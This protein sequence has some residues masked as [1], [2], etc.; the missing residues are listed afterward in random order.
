VIMVSL[1][2]LTLSQS[3]DVSF[4]IGPGDGTVGGFRLGW[5]G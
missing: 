5:F 3:A 1:N 4:Q 2:G